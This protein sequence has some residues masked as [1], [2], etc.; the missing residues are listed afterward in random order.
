[1]SVQDLLAAIRSLSGEELAQLQTELVRD[2]AQPDQSSTTGPV[3]QVDPGNLPP[4]VVTEPAAPAPASPA[5]E[6]PA[7]AP[8]EPAAAPPALS[9]EERVARLEGFHQAG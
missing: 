6:P 5:A 4:N 1:M 3:V 7:A 8:E 9:L 2:P